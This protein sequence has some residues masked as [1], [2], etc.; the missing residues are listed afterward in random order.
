MPEVR[1]DVLNSDKTPVGTLDVSDHATFPLALSWQLG[2]LRDITKRSGTF[3]KSFSL[4]ATK[5]NNKVL[6]YIYKAQIDASSIVYGKDVVLSVD[7]LPVM[8]GKLKVKS[9]G[10]AENPESYELELVGENLDWVYQLKQHSIQELSY[11]NL[12]YNNGSGK[13]VPATTGSHT[14]RADFIECS[15]TGFPDSFDYVYGLKN[16]GA[17]SEFDSSGNAIVNI[18]E[19]RPDVSIAHIVRSSLANTGYS[20]QSDFFDSD[21][22]KN[23]VLAFTGNGFTV[24]E[25]LD[26][27]LNFQA[28]ASAV[29]QQ[30]HIP[31]QTNTQ[32]I[33]EVD[34]KS[35]GDNFDIATYQFTMPVTYRA[36]FKASVQVDINNWYENIKNIRIFIGR[37]DG[38]VWLQEG[39]T[40]VDTSSNSNNQPIEVETGY[41]EF[42]QGTTLAL[43]IHF[44]TEKH[45]ISSHR[46]SFQV[47]DIQ[48]T[49]EI[50]ATIQQNTTYDVASVLPDI[51]QLEV[52]SGLI[53][54]FNLFFKTDTQQK[55]V[56]CEP[57]KDFY[58]D[59]EQAVNWSE[60]LDTGTE[61]KTQYLDNYN[62]TLSF[63]FKSD[64]K[65]GYAKQW[66]SD[67]E[68]YPGS[69]EHELPA[70]FK[71]GT[72]KLGNKLFAYTFCLHDLHLHD[73]TLPNGTRFLGPTIPRLWSKNEDSPAAAYDFTP[74]IL[75]YE[76]F[77]TESSGSDFS[78][79]QWNPDGTI[80]GLFNY[81]RLTM[82][83]I[84]Y[85][86]ASGLVNT[87]YAEDIALMEDGRIINASFYLSPTDI[88][89]LDLRRPVY[90]DHPSLLGYYYINKVHDYQPLKAE[91]TKVE[92]I[93]AEPHTIADIDT[94]N[95]VDYSG[96]SK[97]EPGL[98]KGTGKNAALTTSGIYSNNSTPSTVLNNGTGNTAT[99]GTASVA[100]GQGLHV[101]GNNQTILGTYNQVD[102]TDVF[103][104][105]AGTS[106][107]DRYRGL[108]YTG[109]GNFLV[110]GG[111]L[112]T[113]QG[114]EILFTSQRNAQGQ[115]TRFD[116]LHLRGNQ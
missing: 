44:E 58:F 74:R 88:L 5:N 34:Q 20:L 16:Y 94:D 99:W 95:Q 97:M 106:A 40:H 87:Y 28:S 108:T 101:T 109:D 4:P 64:S 26:Q 29:Y 11:G 96:S 107:I 69:L 68:V 79:W 50:E 65:D 102:A 86:S 89:K 39:I 30:I 18:D 27:S 66:T 93:P 85:G 7:G 72:Q 19:M 82:N 77:V 104:V 55:I 38:N 54:L 2:D 14:L 9:V 92:L 62:R 63:Q 12:A 103:Q 35:F 13:S 100:I 23:L 71:E 21:L 25:A 43:G 3:S 112:Y 73:N 60:K 78:V 105:G 31:K 42:Q 46:P 1:I 91:P 67:N 111:Y 84:A 83:E 48:F 113:S 45:Y 70:R 47:H 80:H 81:P 98:G 114:Q 41:K 51:K 76:G 17:W 53:N 115:P 15:W 33:F 110:Q 57:R 61:I 90:V 24:P 49:N 10:Q 59:T 6:Q 36:N 56:Y 75:R 37:K 116:K 32:E 52:L 22:G 8:E